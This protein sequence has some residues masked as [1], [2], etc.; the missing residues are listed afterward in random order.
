MQAT[1]LN[2]TFVI[3]IGG[4]GSGKNYFIEH[5]PEFSTYQLV[6]V[7]AIKGQLGVSAAIS[8]IK[9]MLLTAFKNKE[10]VAHPTT[11]SNLQA[12]K[13]KI[14]AAKANGYNVLLYLKRTDAHIA[15]GNVRNRVAGGGHDVGLDKIVSS[16]E[17]ARTNF[18][19]LAPLVDQAQIV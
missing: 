8:A 3:V 2:P 17:Q 1:D 13:N 5:H 6:D 9:P 11:A 14:A 10:N 19:L 18:N 12:Q 16:N 4:A 15:A 7:D